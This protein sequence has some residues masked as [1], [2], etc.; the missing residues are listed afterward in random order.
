ME[1]VTMHHED[2]DKSITVRESQVGVYE[3]AGWHKTG[4]APAGSTPGAEVR[5]D[6]ASTEDDAPARAITPPRRDRDV[7]STDTPAA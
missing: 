4:D 7:A 6:D 5:E 2:L 3:K 1:N